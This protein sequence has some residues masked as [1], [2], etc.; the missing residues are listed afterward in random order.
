MERKRRS[1]RSSSSPSSASSSSASSSL[2]TPLMA[3]V[4]FAVAFPGLVDTLVGFFVMEKT[5]ARAVRLPAPS[6]SHEAFRKGGKGGSGGGST[7]SNDDDDAF[8]TSGKGSSNRSGHGDEDDNAP[9][10]SAVYSHVD[11]NRLWHAACQELAGMVQ[12]KVDELHSIMTDER[13]KVGSGFTA[14]ARK[15]ENGSSSSSSSSGGG[16][17]GGGA[18]NGREAAGAAAKAALEEDPSLVVIVMKDSLLQVRN[19]LFFFRE[20]VDFRQFLPN[21]PI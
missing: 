4:D 6:D 9:P 14:L 10:S 11:I 13:A 1:D 21:I 16:G 7:F 8:D 12:K 19:D 20:G 5:I 18:E 17:G 15:G 2:S 3:I